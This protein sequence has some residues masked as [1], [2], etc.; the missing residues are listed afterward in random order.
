MLFH[1][2]NFQLFVQQANTHTHNGT[3][4]VE[5]ISLAV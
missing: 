1:K 5:N 2:K 3:E 4:I